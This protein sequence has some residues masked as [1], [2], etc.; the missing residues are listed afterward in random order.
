[1][2]NKRS[3]LGVWIIERSSGRNIIARSYSEVQIEMDLIAPFLSATHTF[4][5]RASR[6]SLRTIDTE[7]SR[8]VWDAN[9]CLLMV[10]VVSNLARL[11]HMRFVLEYIMREFMQQYLQDVTDCVTVL[12]EW[13][14]SPETFRE[15][16]QFLDEIVSQY[17]VTDE[18]LLIGKAMDCLEVYNHIFRATMQVNVDISTKTKLVDA[19]KESIRPLC[20]QYP[21]LENVPI[22][23]AGI[24]VLNINIL[25]GEISYR[26]LRD[27][28][29]KML[30]VVAS[31]TKRNVDVSA[32]RNM[33]FDS[34][35]PYVKRD[36]LRLQTYFI[37]DDVV[38]SFF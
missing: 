33:I 35:M 30:Q 31:T 37:L 11:S 14:G 8:Y 38:N 18:A 34:L 19:L 3:I 29:E 23:E 36:M 32:F 24:E 6:E 27:A 15:F 16:G 28:L 17:E 22:D 7:N 1:M 9:E 10:M 12:N 4:I 5:D 25:S 2:S 21:F 26:H 13:Q 20:E